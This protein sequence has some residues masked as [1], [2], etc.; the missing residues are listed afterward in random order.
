MAMIVM[1]SLSW[2]FPDN[3]LG[4]CSIVMAMIVIG[5]LFGF[6]YPA[7]LITYSNSTIR[8]VWA[9]S[10]MIVRNPPCDPDMLGSRALHRAKGTCAK[11]EVVVEAEVKVEK[12]KKKQ[13]K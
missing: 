6:F 9:G 1:V 10:L 5:S 11:V 12:K 13:Q 2:G 7:H 8:Q 4:P 3:D